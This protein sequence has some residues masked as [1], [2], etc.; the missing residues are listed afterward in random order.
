VDT[1]IVPFLDEK[2]KP[3]K[4]LAIRADITTRKQAEEVI[5]KM[6]ED[7]EN[8]ITQRTLELTNLLERMQSL[9]EMKSRFVSMASHEFRTPLST[10]LSS[11]SLVEAYQSDEQLEKRKKHINRIRTS[12]RDLIGILNDFL[13]IDKLEQ[14]IIEMEPGNF[15]LDEFARELQEEVNGIL[16]SGQQILYHHTGEKEVVVDKKI[17]KNILLNLLSNASKYSAESKDIRFCIEVSQLRVSI[18][19]ADEGMG[20]PLEDQPKLFGKFYRASNAAKFQGT[21]LGLNI[22]KRYL[23]LLE[24]EISFVSKE[25][26]GTTFKIE[27]PQNQ[28]HV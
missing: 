11:L 18:T 2:R 15:D 20:I 19:I 13:S 21:G 8:K 12:I 27:F 28:S 7:L 14:G 4:Y 5:L 24:G 10:M 23:E 3:F 25:G 6:N 16:K 9:N 26:V 17:L 22:V 1:T